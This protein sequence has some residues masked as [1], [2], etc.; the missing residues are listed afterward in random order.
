MYL[1]LKCDDGTWVIESQE[2]SR[3]VAM[4]LLHARDPEG[5]HSDIW[6]LIDMKYAGI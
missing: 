6:R 2:V 5:E 1:L 3:E 4:N